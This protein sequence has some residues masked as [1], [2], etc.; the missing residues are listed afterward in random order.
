MPDPGCGATGF[1]SEVY[2]GLEFEP[3]LGA[4]GA[5]AIVETDGESDGKAHVDFPAC[6][7]Y[8]LSCGGTLLRASG[9]ERTSET[10]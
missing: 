10:V 5:A 9:G 8:V 3:V 4:A 6:D 7:P 2:A 1:G